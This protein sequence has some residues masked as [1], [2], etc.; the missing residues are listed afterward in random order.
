MAMLMICKGEMKK[1]VIA[2]MLESALSLYHVEAAITAK[3]LRFTNEVDF[4][5]PLTTR[6]VVQ[7]EQPEP[8][9]NWMESYNMKVAQAEDKEAQLLIRWLDEEKPAHSELRL[10]DLAM[11][12]YYSCIQQFRMVKRV[13]Y[14]E[15]LDDFG[16]R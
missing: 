9:C 10:M 13:L 1:L 15:W 3:R 16:S 7:P 12:F 8:D 4:V 6:R 14:Y 5:V 11:R 2:T